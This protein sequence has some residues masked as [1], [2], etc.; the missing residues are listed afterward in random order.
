MLIRKNKSMS[1]NRVV[2]EEEKEELKSEDRRDQQIKRL[3]K[4]IE[5]LREELN[6]NKNNE[7]RWDK[8]ADL[9]NDLFHKG[10]IDESGNFIDKIEEDLIKKFKI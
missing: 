7:D 6:D 4:E 2:F 1:R 10:N 8:Y 3:Q 9:L 5:D